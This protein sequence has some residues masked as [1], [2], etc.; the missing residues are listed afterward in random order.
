M[1]FIYL[2]LSIYLGRRNPLYYLIFPMALVSGPG[3]FIDSRT[4]LF[5]NDIFLIGKN[6]YKDVITLYLFLVV[7]HLRKYWT[8][9]MITNTPIFSYSFYIL[10]LIVFTFLFSGTND[11]AINV[12]R[13]FI[14]MILGYYFI[15]FIFSAA[16]FKQF[17][18]FFNTL[19]FATGILSIC[20]VLNSAKIFPF[21]I[22]ENL[23]QE[24]E[25]G[26]SSFFRDFS[27]IPYFSHLLF[28]LAFSLTLLKSKV[29]NSKALILVL[30]TYPFVLLY[31]FTRSLL[32]IT[33]IECILIVVLIAMKY[34]KRIFSFKTLGIAFILFFSIA[35]IQL[36]LKNELSFFTERISS[37][38]SEGIEENNVAIRIAYHIKAY[39]ILNS[40]NALLLGDGV[41]KKHESEMDEVG[42]WAADSSIPFLLIYTG[43]I[44]VFFYFY[45]HFNFLFKIY[46]QI[47]DHFNA[48]SLTLF[49]TTISFILSSLFMGG[50]RWGDPFIFFPL[51]L[52]VTVGNL[53]KKENFLEISK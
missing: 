43:F 47:E 53:I 1:Q 29:F 51:V 40:S 8:R 49:V 9:N 22:Q 48:I 33:F 44:G 14:H 18:Q 21:F 37:A 11:E 31:T 24:I 23:Y 13:L 3:A 6:I 50:I 4:V 27:T 35:I 7:F 34:P 20:Y 30:A 41:N 36:S 39:E 45:I 17:I 46:G 38:K 52:V 26:G 32:G 2:I 5:G 25:M 42:A 12:M 19:F 28:L 15:T 10:F 16:N